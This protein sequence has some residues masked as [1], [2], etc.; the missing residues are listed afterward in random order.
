MKPP[1]AFTSPLAERMLQFV[2]FKR[3]QGY[4][5]AAGRDQ[6][7]RFEAFLAKHRYAGKGL[8]AEA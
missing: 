5:Y 8:C 6:L 2:A 4:D 1:V 7:K 3:M